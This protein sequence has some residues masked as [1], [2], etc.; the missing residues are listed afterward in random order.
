MSGVAEVS[1]TIHGVTSA[2]SRSEFL[3]QLSQLSVVKAG[4]GVAMA[5]R[6]ILVIDDDRRS[7]ELISEIL[8]A[9]GFEVRSAHGGPSG[10]KLARAVQPAAILL[11]MMMPGID[12]ITT[13]QRLKWDPILADIPVIGMTASSDLTY[14]G[15]AFRAGADFFVSKPLNRGSLVRVVEL[16]VEKVLR[17]TPMRHHRRH[18][19]FQSGIAVRCLVGADT[20][21]TRKVMGSV[22]NV[23]LGGLLLILPEAL[24]PG[25]SLGL[26]LEL[27][28]SAI[29]ATGKVMWQNPQ[30]MVDGRLRHGV[31]LARFASD[32]S[33]VGYRR[34]LSRVAAT[35][36]V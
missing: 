1:E 25:T 22:G 17:G 13:L 2:A 16:A 8:T 4:R 29:P 14:T 32:S 9:A 24:M 31:Q 23:S 19:R 12:G 5:K 21:S 33:L 10:I 7:T 11:D 26:V 18:P 20:G 6:P 27:P 28:E 36:S 3:A 30:K 15:K 35:E 34:Y